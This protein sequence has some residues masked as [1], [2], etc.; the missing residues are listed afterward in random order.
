[1]DEL[2]PL[3]ELVELVELEPFVADDPADVPVELPLEVEGGTE[4]ASG[5]VPPTAA[6]VELNQE[7]HDATSIEETF[8]ETTSAMACA[9]A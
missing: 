2:D 8:C 5:E 7:K 6:Q 3:V 9:P 1:L 4:F